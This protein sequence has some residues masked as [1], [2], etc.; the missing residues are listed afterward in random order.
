MDKRIIDWAQ[1]IKNETNAKII[2]QTNGSLLNETIAK[3]L[4][5][6]AELIVND[7]TDDK[8]VMK[9]IKKMGGEYY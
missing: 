4:G 8:I 6:Y 3:E 1:K 2:I 7:Y 5:Q 9:K